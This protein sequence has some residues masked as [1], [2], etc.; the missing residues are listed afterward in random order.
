MDDTK[1]DVLHVLNKLHDV[2]KVE[3][4]GESYVVHALFSSPLSFLSRRGLEEK[5][6]LW[7]QQKQA[8]TSKIVEY[9]SRG[10]A[11]LKDEAAQNG[12]TYNDIAYDVVPQFN[13]DE[14][15]ICLNL[16]FNK[17]DVS[18]EQVEER[19]K[20][21]TQKAI[22]SVEYTSQ[23]AAAY[24][25]AH[26]GFLKSIINASQLDERQEPL[27]SAVI[28][29]MYRQH[30]EVFETSPVLNFEVP[31]NPK[32]ENG[33]RNLV[34]FLKDTLSNQLEDIGVK[35]IFLTGSIIPGDSN[36]T[37]YFL[38]FIGAKSIND[39][40]NVIRQNER[41]LTE[42]MRQAFHPTANALGV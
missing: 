16:V 24:K 40:V 6:E 4:Q 15:Q 14:K 20:E 29:E 36:K 41:Q 39:V 13:L 1:R 25:I 9:L 17:S 21:L 11:L 35:D 5:P 18:L 8:I 42:H 19:V 12:E 33:V 38:H 27:P 32:N 10:E 23:R 2:P 28:D 3:E 7:E 30:G 26:E 37:E 31:A 34:L 22:H